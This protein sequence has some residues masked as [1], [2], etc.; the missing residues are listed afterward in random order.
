MHPS[1]GESVA[2]GCQSVA[3]SVAGRILIY[4]YLEPSW[5]PKEPKKYQKTFFKNIIYRISVVSVARLPEEDERKIKMDDNEQLVGRERK[6]PV[7][8]KVF[9][10]ADEEW[11]YKRIRDHKAKYFCSWG[12]LCR[13]EQTRPK[14]V[15]KDQ[16]EDMIRM[17]KEGKGISEIVR[18]LGVDRSKVKYWKER[19]MMDDGT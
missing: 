15:A 10:L 11:A 19:V 7:C 6:C 4:Q 16:R 14:R 9:I 5:Q 17:L 2:V 18:T 8:E 13:Y 3:G 1:G 12:C